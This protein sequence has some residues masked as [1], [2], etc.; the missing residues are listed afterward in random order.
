MGLPPFLL[1]DGLDCRCWRGIV[2][3]V[4]VVVVVVVGEGV[5]CP[6]SLVFRCFRGWCEAG[7]PLYLQQRVHGKR[8]HSMALWEAMRPGCGG[9]AA[10]SRVRSSWCCPATLT[11][12]WLL[13]AAASTTIAPTQASCW[14]A[15]KDMLMLR[16]LPSVAVLLPL[17]P[18]CHLLLQVVQLWT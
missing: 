15:L 17:S 9:R 12:L 7:S 1:L 10:H 13:P 16:V 6:H 18:S 5:E 14:P 4:V 11:C 3:G 2:V 8:R